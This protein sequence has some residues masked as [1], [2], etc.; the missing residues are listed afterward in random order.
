MGV[1]VEDLRKVRRINGVKRAERMEHDQG[2]SWT[3]NVGQTDN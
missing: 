2:N 3:W 1:G